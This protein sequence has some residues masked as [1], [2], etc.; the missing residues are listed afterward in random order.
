MPEM[1]QKLSRGRHDQVLHTRCSC[2][3][4][5]EKKRCCSLS[6]GKPFNCKE[7]GDGKVMKC[8]ACRGVR[9]NN[10]AKGRYKKD[11]VTVITPSLHF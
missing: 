1:H 2:I 7:E 8:F 3:R 5:H 4:G 9:D 11:I 6:M 10:P